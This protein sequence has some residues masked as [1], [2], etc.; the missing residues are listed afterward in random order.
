MGLVFFLPWVLAQKANLRSGVSLHEDRKL[1]K[2]SGNAIDAGQGEI[3][4]PDTQWYGK[5][6]Y[7]HGNPLNYPN[8]GKSTIH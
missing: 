5:N 2:F 4:V 8:V 1:R 6:I 3:P 7:L